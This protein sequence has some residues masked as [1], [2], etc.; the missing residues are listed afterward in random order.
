MND[1][2]R[3]GWVGIG[4]L[5]IENDGRP[6]GLLGVVVPL[7]DGVLAPVPLALLIAVLDDDPTALN[8]TLPP[9]SLPGVSVSV[10]PDAKSVLDP[11]YPLPLAVL[12][13]PR[14]ASPSVLCDPL[15]LMV[16]GGVSVGLVVRL[17]SRETAR[18]DK[19]GNGRTFGLPLA[20][21][22]L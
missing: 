10:G 2:I 5:A 15:G 14:D 1:R 12:S 22:E 4:K 17:A 7:P 20:G 19:S 21:D 8:D 18:T 11:K 16:K 9:C 3:F 6:S 13:I